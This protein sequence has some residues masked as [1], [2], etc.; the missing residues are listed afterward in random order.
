MTA[1]SLLTYFLKLVVCG[2]AFMIGVGVSGGV[3]PR[4]G[5][6]TP[7]MPEGVDAKAV[8]AYT[9]AG[10]LFVA[11][12]L[13]QVAA[14]IA[15]RM[16]ERWLALA[17]LAWVAWGV[18]TVLEASIFTVYEQGTQGAPFTILYSL[19]ASLSVALAVAW[20]FPGP[21]PGAGFWAAANSFFSRYTSGEWAWRLAGALAAFPAI[22]YFFGTLISPIVIGYYRRNSLGLTLPKTSVILRMQVV[23]SMLFLVAVLPTL[24]LWHP[25]RSPFLALGLALFVLVGWTVVFVAHWLPMPLRLTHGLEILVDSL[26][27]AWVVT[28]LL[29]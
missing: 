11:L 20:L 5:L 3:L 29:G 26:L 14:G 27:Y 10:S 19:A 15:G 18:N 7:P 12:A 13:S 25:G 9:A 21:G 17:V 24:V 2:L 23:R 4:L 1:L 22:Y 16:L 28:R 6:K 8:G